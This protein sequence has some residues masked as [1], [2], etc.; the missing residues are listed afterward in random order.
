MQKKIVGLACGLLLVFAFSSQSTLAG[1]ADKLSFDSL[2]LESISSSRTI[3]KSNIAV[4]QAQLGINDAIVTSN[5]AAGMLDLNRKWDLF[6]KDD[7]LQFVKL[8]D[9]TPEQARY[10]NETVHASK[11]ITIN[12]LKVSLREIYFGLDNAESNLSIKNQR[13]RMAEKKLAEAKVKEQQ[14][15]ID[16]LELA[17]I[18]YEFLKAGKEVDIAKR[19]ITKLQLKMNSMAGLD[20]NQAQAAFSES[21]RTEKLKSVDHYIENALKNRFEIIDLNRQILL[22]ELEIGLF[23]A[24]GYLDSEEARQDYRYV[25][26]DYQKLMTRIDM[27]RNEIEAE[28]RQAYHDIAAVEGQIT[29]LQNSLKNA[30]EGLRIM[31][32]RYGGGLIDESVLVE[33]ELSTKEME[34]QLKALQSTYNT[35]RLKLDYASQIG[36]G[37]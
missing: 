15:L 5:Q 19:E 10:Q 30:Q 7:E 37:Y 2:W 17:E 4:Y 22:K 9:L 31:A 11:Q 21:P 25:T 24:G 20:L 27:V 12:T 26:Y 18:D 3:K 23:E 32:K 28:I 13:L 6:G 35:K 16:K 34:N 36:P 8:R 29:Q 14:G 33:T 1:Q